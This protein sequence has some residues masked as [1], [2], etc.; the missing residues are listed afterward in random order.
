MTTYTIDEVFGI[1]RHLP[2]N[3]VEREAVDKKLQKELRAK[4]H[5]VIYGSSKQGKTSVRKHCLP[6]ESYILVQCSNKSDMADLHANIL[7]RAGFEIT[8]SSKKSSSGKNKIIASVKTGVKGTLLGFGGSAEASGGAEGE[9]GTTEEIT[10]SPLELD[11]D[12]VNDVIAALKSIAFDKLIVLE[13]FHYLPYETQKDFSIE[14]KAF[15][16]FSAITFIV[17]GV[18]L[19]DNRLIVYNGDLTGRVIS[20]NADHWSNSELHS[21]ITQGGDLLGVNFEETFA[22]Q[23]I[24][25]ARESVYVVQ[26]GCRI[27]CLAANITETQQRPVTIG[28]GLDVD[29]IVKSIVDQQSARYDSF[30][31]NFADGFQDTDL[32]MYRW[33]LYTILSTPIEEIESGLRYRDIRGI[34]SEKHPRKSDLNAGN[35]IQALQS[36]ASLQVKKN[37]MPIIIDYDQSS[38]NL[39]VV[40]KGFLIWLQH[41]DS[42]ELLNDIG[43]P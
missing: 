21:V 23:L 38:K 39:H 41:Q 12:D 20:V 4:H 25:L 40:D 6:D 8:Q 5:I 2:L 28:A 30:L 13:D 37:I 31:T 10:T 27:A 11:I 32:Q 24:G 19:E 33:L 3:Y 18:W 34:L 14:L 35:I 15:H 43:V 22:N 29:E 36:S 17:V 16:E 1:T 7:K 26:E 42:S 9:T